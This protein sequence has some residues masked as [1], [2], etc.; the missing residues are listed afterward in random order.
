MARGQ[1]YKPAANEEADERDSFFELDASAAAAGIT[2]GTITCVLS[3]VAAALAG[4]LAGLALGGGEAAP[5]TATFTGSEGT[6]QLAPQQITWVYVADL[7]RGG[8]FL[9]DV[10][11]LHEVEGMKQ[12]DS[13]RI[14]MASPGHFCGV[15]DTRQPPDCREGGPEREDNVGK[16][17]YSLIVDSAAEVDAWFERL[18]PHNTS[19]SVAAAARGKVHVGRLLLPKA[20]AT[21][22]KFACYS[23]LF[24]DT[25]SENGLGCYRFEVQYFTDPAWPA[26][27]CV[28]AVTPDA[29]ALPADANATPHATPNDDALPDVNAPPNQN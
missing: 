16:V 2:H 24:Y 4:L 3:A 13:C 15:C 28:A 8:S 5:A 23:F 25:D 1:G 18:L 11:G 19:S 10:L 21:S 7:E 27:A 22:A 9:G 29:D 26:P 6:D 17:T 20:P 14:F 12:R